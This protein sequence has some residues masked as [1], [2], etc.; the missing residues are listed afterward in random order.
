MKVPDTVSDC[1]IYLYTMEHES[2]FV[3]ANGNDNGH[4]AMT[5]TIDF[6]NSG[7]AKVT[8]DSNNA[9]T[10]AISN[11]TNVTLVLK[12]T[13][14]YKSIIGSVILGDGDIEAGWMCATSQTDFTGNC[15][16][17]DANGTYVISG[18]SPSD[19]EVYS[20]QYWAS[21]GETFNVEATWSDS[22]NDLTVDMDI[23][24][25]TLI[26]IIGTVTDSDVTSAP[27]ETVL[28][29]VNGTNWKVLDAHALTL[30]TNGVAVDFSFTGLA[31]VV[32]GHHYEIA[33]ANR[34]MN[35]T[36]GVTSYIVKGA[37][38]SDGS[39]TTTDTISSDETI[40]ITFN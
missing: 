39:A 30:D 26:D 11:E 33:V 9:D 15:G 28:L 6:S 36:T 5:T 3:D 25:A 13:D 37:I 16:E 27:V 34:D 1:Y 23:A 19:D 20:V 17:V 12:S 22:S 14:D 31:P 29:D 35:M 8:W 7:S 4:D 2:G 38:Q 40:T 24:S 10:L 21:T 18:L 32:T